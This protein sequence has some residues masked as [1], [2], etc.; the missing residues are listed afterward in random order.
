RD[1]ADAERLRQRII[2]VQ[3]AA[4]GQLSGFPSTLVTA[5]AVG[6]GGDD[7]A[8]EGPGLTE[9][10]RDIVLVGGALA[11]LADEAD[12]NL[13]ISLRADRHVR[14]LPSPRN[15]SRNARVVRRALRR[16]RP[17]SCATGP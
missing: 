12:A 9:T 1:A 5:D 17:M 2:G 13:K 3:K 4:D 6:H 16:L 14:D 11:G 8:V 15:A 10:G 7:V